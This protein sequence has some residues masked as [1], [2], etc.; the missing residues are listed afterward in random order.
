[1]NPHRLTTIQHLLR[2]SSPFGPPPL[3]LLPKPAPL[4]TFHHSRLSNPFLK[5]RQLTLNPHHQHVLLRVVEAPCKPA[6]KRYRDI[7]SDWRF[8]SWNVD[9]QLAVVRVKGKGEWVFAVSGGAS[10]GYVVRE[11]EEMEVV[12]MQD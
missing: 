9:G 6:L 2:A 3:V 5:V 8:N 11:G 7:D 12:E 1:M 10:I 4:S